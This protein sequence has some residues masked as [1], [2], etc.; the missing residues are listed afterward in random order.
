MT[1]ALVDWNTSGHHRMHMRAFAQTLLDSGHRVIVLYP[2]PEEILDVI[3]QYYGVRDFSPAFDSGIHPAANVDSGTINCPVKSGTEV[4]HSKNS[5]FAAAPFH[6]VKYPL[7]PAP[8]RH[9]AE[10]FP[11]VSN[12]KKQLA[13]CERQLGAPCDFVFFNCLYEK[14]AWMLR[15]LADACAPRPWSF[16]YLHANAFPPHTGKNKAV[17]RLL[18]HDRLHSIAVLDERASDSGQRLT[19]RP[20]VVFP[21]FTTTDYEP[22]HPL[23]R[24]LLAFKGNSPLVLAIGHLLRNKNY[25]TL[26]QAALRPEARDI[27]FAFIGE[28]SRHLR[29]KARCLNAPNLY[30]K[31]DYIETDAAY[32][33]CIR[34]SDVLFAAYRDFEHSSNTL[35]KAAAFER[36][37]IVSEGPLSLMA[38]RAREYNLGEIVPQDDATAVLRAIR[39]LTSPPQPNQPAAS[40]RWADY[41]ERHSL[42]ALRDAFS[43]TI[44]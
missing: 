11:I 26:L 8:L 21:D 28:C 1:I 6:R 33:A 13:A 43:K 35:A 30:F 7:W 14:Q 39:K 19:N 4:P 25:Q 32:N 40:R 29:Q 31:L 9:W 23:E 36:P 24:D 42:A 5:S 38:Q 37:V 22:S 18:Q 10:T 17:Q 2:Q 20:I 3:N 16:L 44:F 12:F 34:A 41:R 27:K 15:A